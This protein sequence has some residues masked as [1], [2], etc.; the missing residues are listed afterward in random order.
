MA[1]PE[2][3]PDEPGKS[4]ILAL[5]AWGKIKGVAKIGRQPVANQTIS[6]ARRDYRPRAVHEFYHI[7]TRTDGQGRFAFDRV[8]PCSS[9]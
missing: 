4:G 8:I 7:S 5:R 6:V 3:A 9:A 2:S 1:S